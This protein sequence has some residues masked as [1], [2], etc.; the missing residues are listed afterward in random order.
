MDSWFYSWLSGNGKAFPFHT[1][2]K[3]SEDSFQPSV[4]S[5]RGLLLRPRLRGGSGEEE[6]EAWAGN[7]VYPLSAGVW[8]LMAQGRRAD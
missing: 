5:G 8:E 3:I 4:L 7:E 6:E 1:C 2:A